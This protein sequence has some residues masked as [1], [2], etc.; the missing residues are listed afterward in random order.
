MTRFFNAIASA[1]SSR[2]ARNSPHSSSIPPNVS[3]NFAIS[4]GPWSTCARPCRHC[5][6]RSSASASAVLMACTAESNPSEA[7]IRPWSRRIAVALSMA[8]RHP[9]RALRSRRSA[10]LCSFSSNVVIFSI[11]CWRLWSAWALT[12]TARAISTSGAATVKAPAPAAAT[13]AV[14]AEPPA[15]PAAAAFPAT[16]T[17]VACAAIFEEPISALRTPPEAAFDAIGLTSPLP[18]CAATL[19]GTTMR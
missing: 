2:W 9:L 5:L 3:R 16:G 17:K 1:A 8:S 10:S 19:P 6:R 7:P 13:P 18:T 15:A 12:P 11:A 4:T 14:A